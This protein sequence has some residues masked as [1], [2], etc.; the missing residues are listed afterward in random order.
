MWILPIVNYTKTRIKES[1]KDLLALE[2]LYMMVQRADGYFKYKG[3]T[4]D[5]KEESNYTGLRNRHKK[6]EMD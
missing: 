1:C 5:V 6:V 2:A 4:P 3:W